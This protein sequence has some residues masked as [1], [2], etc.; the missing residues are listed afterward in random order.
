MAKT[1][2]ATRP[3]ELMLMLAVDLPEDTAQEIIERVR[4]HITS[5]DGEIQTF[6]PWGR[7]RLAYPIQH[8]REAIYH[9]ARFSLAPASAYELD[10]TLQRNEHVLRHLLVRVD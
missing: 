8:L 5:N 4:T 2:T 1:E 6:E 7:R 10:H 3:Y 9:L